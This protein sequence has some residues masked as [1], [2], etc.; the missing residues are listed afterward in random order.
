MRFVKEKFDASSAEPTGWVS[1]GRLFGI[2]GEIN[3]TDE[4]IELLKNTKLADVRGIHFLQE[5]G[6][7]VIELVWANILQ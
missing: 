6:E 1:P 4:Q 3:F 2:I 5:A 7:I